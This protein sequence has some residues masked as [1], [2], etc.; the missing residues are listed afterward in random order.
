MSN[1]KISLITMGQGNVNALKKTLD[2]FKPFVDEVVY[3]DLLIFPEDREVVKTYE[4]Q[5]NLRS[6]RLPFNYIFK[7][8]FSNCLNFLISNAKND[9][10]LYMNTSEVID[11]DYGINDLVNS[12]PNCNSFYFSHR[13]EKHRWFRLSDR[14]EIEWSGRLHEEPKGEIRPYHKPIFMMKDEEKDLD[15]PFKAAVFNS[16]K[17]MA[18]WS[19]LIRMVDNPKEQGST[20]DYWVNFAKSQYA[21]MKQRLADKGRQYEAFKIGDF[22]MFWE[23]VHTS[24]YFKTAKFESS[25]SI[26]FQGSTKSL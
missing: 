15:N 3:G 13:Q 19:Q 1:R 8:G 7:M 4:L 20:N 22:G 2:S 5:Y 12:N 11:E 10:C 23:D 6:I 18:Y 25:Q 9:L 24:D 16:I 17:E 26:E 14:R 21:S